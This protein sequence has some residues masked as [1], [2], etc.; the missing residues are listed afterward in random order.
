MNKMITE[1][2]RVIL[3][4]EFSIA[5]ANLVPLSYLMSVDNKRGNR[6]HSLIFLTCFYDIYWL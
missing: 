5:Q 6:M 1:T 4:I 2:M 3:G